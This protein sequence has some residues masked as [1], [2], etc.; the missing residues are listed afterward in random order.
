MTAHRAKGL[1]FD[2]V[3]IMGVSHGHWSNKKNRKHFHIPI[4]G[5][6]QKAGQIDDERRLFYV[7]LT[8]AKN[9][10]FVSYSKENREGK[11]LLPAQFIGEIDEKY[12]IV[13]S[14]ESVIKMENTIKKAIGHRFNSLPK[15]NSGEIKNKE[16]LQKIFLDQ[17]LSVTALNN[18]LKCPWQYFFMNLL[19]IPSTQN[20]NQMYGTAIH[21]TLQ[22]FFEKYRVDIDLSKKELLE[23]FESNLK[24]MA[25]SYGDFTE[26]LKKGRESLGTYFDNYKDSWQKNLITEFDIRGIHLPIK[27]DDVEFDLIL[28]GKLDKIEL[29]SKKNV[30]VVDYKTGKIKSRNTI[31]GK[32]KDADGNYKRQLVFYKILLDRDEKKKYNMISGELDFIEPDEKGKNKK[33][34]FEI[35]NEEVTDLEK[36]ITEKAL[37][38]YKFDFWN[39]TC[40]DKK[41]EFCALGKNLNFN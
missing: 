29:V 6:D 15:D 17:G 24:K 22:T 4:L 20:K 41:C 9:A 10:V 40:K 12:K 37:E 36:L 14:G 8:R 39:K 18:Y 38:I 32:T 23:I 11:E 25:F 35:S 34:K 2:F 19:R 30:N 7:A 31:L 3:Y 1:E 13:H 27:N 33:E 5:E 26:T 21:N 28:K 16:Y